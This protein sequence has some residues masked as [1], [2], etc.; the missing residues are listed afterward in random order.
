M[1]PDL[2]SRHEM[3][4]SHSL[5]HSSGGYEGDVPPLGTGL[6]CQQT[7]HTEVHHQLQLLIRQDAADTQHDGTLQV[8]PYAQI[9]G[10]SAHTR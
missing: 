3:R 2:R 10:E 8:V 7:G 6:Q 4:V 9:E 1:D 5:V